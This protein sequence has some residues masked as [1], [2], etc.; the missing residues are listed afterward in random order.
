[1]LFMA[2]CTNTDFE[3]LHRSLPAFS[4]SEIEFVLRQS[5]P[6]LFPLDIYGTG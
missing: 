1:M 2:V 6:V 4:F 3:M 5:G